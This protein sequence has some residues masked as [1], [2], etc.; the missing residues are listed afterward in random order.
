M[1]V[2]EPLLPSE[3]PPSYEDA[4]KSPLAHNR[5]ASQARRPPPGP[6]PPLNLPALNELRGSRVVLA[7]A[8]P[9]RR[10]LLA[11]VGLTKIDVVPSKF[12]EN[13]DHSLGALNYVL[14]TASAKAHDVYRT[15]I[16]NAERGEPGILIAAD[17]II[18]SHDG[19]ILEKPRSEADHL[20]ML[21]M[22][23][24]QGEH[25]VMTAVAV[26]RPLESAVE[27]GYAMETHVEE[28]TVRF[29]PTVTDELILAYVKTRD[30][31]DK[32]GGYGIQSGGSIL[33]ERIEGSYDNVVGLPLRATLKLI[34]KVMVPEEEQ[35]DDFFV[36]STEGDE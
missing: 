13:L 30:G 17:T 33:I 1:D 26:M 3:P 5:S 8:S 4:R 27:P 36:D 6:P 19:R 32:A 11:Q 15:E 16:N 7:S 25:K 28:T 14:Q 12:A 35:G 23:R 21:K 34:E 20:S 18:V 29:D 22:L 2:K 31:N 10:Q 9:R 24:D